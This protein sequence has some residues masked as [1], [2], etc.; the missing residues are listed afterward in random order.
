MKEIKT[1]FF[2]LNELILAA[3]GTEYESVWRGERDCWPWEKLDFVLFCGKLPP[4]LLFH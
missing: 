4:L 3:V 2:Y 1:F